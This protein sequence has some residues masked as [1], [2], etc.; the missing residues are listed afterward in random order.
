MTS[1]LYWFDAKSGKFSAIVKR[2]TISIAVLSVVHVLRPC[3]HRNGLIGQVL[4][5]NLS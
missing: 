3:I 2:F 5:D 1:A 4:L